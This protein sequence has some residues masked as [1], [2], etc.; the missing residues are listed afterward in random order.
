MITEIFFVTWVVVNSFMVDCCA[1]QPFYTTDAYGIQHMNPC[2]NQLLACFDSE[3]T[4]MSREFGTLEAAEG[5]VKEAQKFACDDEYGQ[6][7]IPGESCL[8]DFK[9][10]RGVVENLTDYK[11]GIKE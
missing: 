9:I 5:F 3:T 10:E 8:K 7:L 11:G 4:E 1:G 6:P 2:Y